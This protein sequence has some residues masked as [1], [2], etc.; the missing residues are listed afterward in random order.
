[1]E[2]GGGCRL[3]D[4][5]Q[6]SLRESRPHAARVDH[7]EAWLEYIRASQERG[8]PL[9]RGQAQGRAAL[10]AVGVGRPMHLR[11][12]LIPGVGFRKL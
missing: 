1:M 6:E 5:C 2:A 3:V 11:A 10:A 12:P 8:H 7:D 4:E 9:L